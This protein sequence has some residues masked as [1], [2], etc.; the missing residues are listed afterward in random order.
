[1]EEGRTEPSG[2]YIH[3]PF[4]L[5]KCDYCGFY[6]IAGADS[7][8][9]MRFAQA[10][11]RELRFL[12]PPGLQ[13]ASIFAGGG[14]PILMEPPFWKSVLEM[15]SDRAVLLQ[16]AEIT[17]EAN[18]AAA[19]RDDLSELRSIGFNRISLGVQS[20][21]DSNLAFLGRV[22]SAEQGMEA[23]EDARRAGFEN[24]SL[25]LIYGVPGQSLQEWVKDLREAVEFGVP[26]VSCYALTLEEGTPY[27]TAVKE[28]GRPAPEE[29]ALGDFYLSA[30]EELGQSGYEHYEVSNFA[31]GPRWRCRHNMGYWTG[32]PYLGFGPSAHSFDGSR[33]RWWNTRD[34]AEYEVLLEASQPP[35]GGDEELDDRQILLERAML[36]LRT[37]DGF[38]LQAI[39][40]R[41]FHPSLVRKLLGTWEAEGLARIDGLRI[42]PTNRGMFVADGLAANLSRAVDLDRRAASAED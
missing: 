15:I 38:D 5:R 12:L 13:I 27:A 37:S 14:T 30:I 42:R 21:N 31:F 36:G 6:S 9:A 2:L 1:M 16:D 20:F 25:D 22:H 24:I 11:Q 4:C 32:R 23:V 40:P 33:R 41:G 35:A 18:P 39:L 28:Q 34:L 7:D 17:I 19:S 10:L 29:S 26:H 8:A 3:V